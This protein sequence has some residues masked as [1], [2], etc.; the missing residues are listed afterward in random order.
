MTR[1]IRMIQIMTTTIRFVSGDSLQK[2]RE[3]IS[4]EKIKKSPPVLN[5]LRSHPVAADLQISLM[6]ENKLKF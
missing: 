4:A 3:V 6:F 1:M 2:L 5:V